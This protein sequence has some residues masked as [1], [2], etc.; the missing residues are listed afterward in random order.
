MFLFHILGTFSYSTTYILHFTNSQGVTLSVLWGYAPTIMRVSQICSRLILTNL[1]TLFYCPYNCYGH[2]NDAL[3]LNSFFEKYN[4]VREWNKLLIV[5]ALLL[6]YITLSCY[7]GTAKIGKNNI[8][9][10]RTVYTS[11]PLWVSSLSISNTYTASKVPFSFL[12]CICS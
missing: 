11:L 7:L 8:E 3:F 1:V 6:P 9:D 2:L 5:I 4:T 12:Y 10:C